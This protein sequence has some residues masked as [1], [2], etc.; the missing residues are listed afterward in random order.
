MSWFTVVVV[1]VYC[2][3]VV[4]FLPYS[5]TLKM[6]AKIHGLTSPQPLH[7]MVYRLRALLWRSGG[8][9]HLSVQTN[10]ASWGSCLGGKAARTWSWHWR[11]SRTYFKS[12][13]S[14]VSIFTSAYIFMAWCFWKFH[15]SRF[16]P[17]VAVE[18]VAHLL[19]IRESQVHISIRIFS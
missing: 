5:S 4:Y 7:C 13:W 15:V 18:W 2:C 6:D 16:L 3:T 19:R 10:S 8:S 12:A 9:S 14:C 17:N 11:L 1:V